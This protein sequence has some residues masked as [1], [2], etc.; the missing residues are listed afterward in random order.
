MRTKWN[1]SFNMPGSGDPDPATESLVWTRT[2]PRLTESEPTFQQDPKV[3]FICTMQ[4]EK[5]DLD[6]HGVGQNNQGRQKTSYVPHTEAKLS[7]G[8]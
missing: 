1:L 2:H 3:I 6:S 8:L 4:L 5:P 7:F